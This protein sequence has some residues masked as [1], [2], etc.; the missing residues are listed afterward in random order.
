MSSAALKVSAPQAQTLVLDAVDWRLYSRLLDTF[1]ERPRIRLTYDHG[2]LEIM[3]P[4]LAHDAE[5]DFFGDLV[6]VLA[7]AYG[8]PLKRGGSVTI[9]L[10]K[11]ERGIEPDRCFWLTNASRLA[12]VRRLDL[13]VH[14]PPDLAIEIDVTH[15][16]MDRVAI[17]ATLGVPE[18]WRLEAEELT[19]HVLQETGEYASAT[20]SRAFPGV[21]PKELLPFL[22][23][24]REAGDETPLMH[25]FRNWVERRARVQRRRRP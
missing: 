8:L 21:Q 24:A 5:A 10:R 7:E 13:R 20:Q 23:E 2:R 18:L 19:F 16:S 25:R 12:G 6:K 15:S 11:A 22:L 9:R 4:L 1:A 3:A 17:Y 14:P